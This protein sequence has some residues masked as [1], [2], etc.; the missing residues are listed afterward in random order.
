MKDSLVLKTIMVWVIIITSYLFFYLLYIWDFI[1]VPL[2]ASIFVLISFNWIYLFFEKFFKNK[3]VSVFLTLWVFILFFVLT[4]YI[5]SNQVWNFIKDSPK[6]IDWFQNFLV[7]LEKI[8]WNFDLDL[9]K[10]FDFNNLKSILLKFSFVWKNIFWSFMWF[11]GLTFT[12][13]VMFGFLFFERKDFRNKA[14][15]LFD[16]KWEKKL[17]NIYDRIQSDLNV[18]FSA[19]FFLALTNAVIATFIMYMFWLDF[20]L[21][22]GLIVFIMDFIPIVWALIA[23]WLPFLYS[24]VDNNFDISR[25]FIMLICL[26]IPQLIT[27]NIIEPKIMWE[28]LNI[29]SIFLVISLL[30]WSQLWWIMW[31]FLATPI[32]V[33]LNI[34]FSKF[35]ATKFISIILSKKFKPEKKSN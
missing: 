16:T 8:S 12:I 11:L 31:A 2:V 17:V 10:Y 18:Y 30:F 29:S 9:K 15:F 25:S 28:R 1:F 35:E 13:L 21:T 22:F 14:K 20:A 34:A 24:F 33:A 27:W 5:L 23:L 6:I 26:Y 32:I 19:K 3:F 4:W 7:S